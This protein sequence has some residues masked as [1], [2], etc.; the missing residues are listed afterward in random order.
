M[1]LICLKW[2]VNLTV[3]YSRTDFCF[4]FQILFY[5]TLVCKLSLKT[6]RIRRICNHCDRT[7]MMSLL[8]KSSNE[9]LIQEIYQFTP[10]RIFFEHYVPL[11]KFNESV[12]CLCFQ[13][14][15]IFQSKN[16]WINYP[17]IF[18]FKVDML[19]L[20]RPPF[21]ILVNLVATS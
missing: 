6:L 21:S 16:I 1:N 15:A 18:W 7:E 13:I 14:S 11:D 5:V 10:F 2:V 3:T 8:E 4:Q 17:E 19:I 9:T 20:L 12:Y